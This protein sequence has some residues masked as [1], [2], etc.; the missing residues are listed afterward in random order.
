MLPIISYCGR[1]NRIVIAVINL[2]CALSIMKINIS[3]GL[4]LREILINVG[5]QAKAEI[6]NLIIFKMFQAQHS[7]RNEY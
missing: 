7:G 1:E 4:Y 5:T 3:Q 2:N 6:W